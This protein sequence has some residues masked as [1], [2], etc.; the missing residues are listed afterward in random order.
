MVVLRASTSISPDCSAVKRCCAVIGTYFVLV[1]SPNTAAAKPRHR[2]TSMP[3]QLPL[4]SG[5]EKPATPVLTPQVTTPRALTASSVAPAC[6][7]PPNPSAAAQAST[8]DITILFTMGS[9]CTGLFEAFL[10]CDG[11]HKG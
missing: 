10:D 4:A 9:S 5:I 1:A 8:A 6:A 11:Q 3:V 7:P 2:S